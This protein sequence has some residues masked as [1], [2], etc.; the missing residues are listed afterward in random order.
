LA[1]G[2][3]GS[4]A[5]SVSTS[6]AIVVGTSES[7]TGMEAFRWTSVGGMVGLGRLHGE[8][9]QSGSAANGISSDGSVVVGY[10]F[11]TSGYSEA[12]RWTSASGMVGL[13][14]LPTGSVASLAYATSSDGSV[15]VGLSG[16]QAFRWTSDTG[17]VGLGLLPH[18]PF[19]SCAFNV[20][21]DGSVVVGNGTDH[22]GNPEAFR[23]TNDSGMIGLGDLPDGPAY[24]LAYGTSG[25]G[26][27]VVG[28]GASAV[29]FEAFRWT[30]DGGMQSLWD[31]LLANGV[32]PAASGWSSPN[33]ASGISPDGRT[34]VG[35]GVR[36]G[37]VEAFRAVVPEPTSLSPLALFGVMLL[38]RSRK[39][40]F[41]Q[42]RTI[43]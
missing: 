29:G 36:N 35:W 27:I 6:G 5:Y 18:G 30:N 2:E 39:L 24:S 15:V 21:G 17:M 32:D 28:L 42:L 23:W 34:V 3:T 22:N 11:T 31:Y 19:G 13:G 40:L 33:S 43:K 16:D 9:Y 4:L 8:N 37:N 20:S 1:G 7:G 25:D 26:S 12:M 14:H 41:S 10:G 38:Q